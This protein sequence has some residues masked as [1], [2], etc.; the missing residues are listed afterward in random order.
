MDVR[1]QSASVGQTASVKLA[2][3]LVEFLAHVQNLEA[4]REP[5]ASVGQTASVQLEPVHAL[6]SLF[7]E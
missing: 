1:E 7:V 3:A 6:H 4:A 5:T 2:P